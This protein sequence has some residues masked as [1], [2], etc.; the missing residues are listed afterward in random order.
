MSRC[1]IFGDVAA[2]WKEHYDLTAI[3]ERDWSTPWT[4]TSGQAEV[5]TWGARTLISRPMPFTI[6]KTF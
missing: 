2:Y 4:D 5:C 6:S 3:F 1:S